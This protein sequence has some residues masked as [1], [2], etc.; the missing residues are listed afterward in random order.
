MNQN[1]QAQGAGIYLPMERISVRFI[2][3][4]FIFNIVK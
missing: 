3:S 4:Q 1:E 2:A